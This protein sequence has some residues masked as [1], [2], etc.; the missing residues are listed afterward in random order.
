[1][2]QQPLFSISEETI[3]HLL[4]ENRRSVVYRVD[5]N[6]VGLTD[7]RELVNFAQMKKAFEKRRAFV[8]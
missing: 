7:A 5:W 3:Q 6:E 2:A 8:A 1:M 4:K